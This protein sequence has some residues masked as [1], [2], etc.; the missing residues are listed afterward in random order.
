MIIKYEI[1]TKEKTVLL[2]LVNPVYHFTLLS[3][4]KPINFLTVFFFTLF[5]Q[6]FTVIA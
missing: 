1:L 6:N 3:L 5:K 4:S 2:G